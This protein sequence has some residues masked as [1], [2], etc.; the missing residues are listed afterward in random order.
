MRFASSI[1]TFSC[2]ALLAFVCVTNARPLRAQCESRPGSDG[3][4]AAPSRP[5]NANTADI[6]Q[7]GVTEF[8][9][10][11]SRSLMGAGASQTDLPALLRFSP[12]CNLEVRMSSDN[13]MSLHQNGETTHGLGDS[14]FTAQYEL[15]R[16]T[17]YLPSVALAYSV[18]FPIADS[19][20]G[21]GSGKYD[22][23]V[24]FLTNKSIGQT[25]FTFNAGYN[26]VGRPG[27]SG[28][29]RNTYLAANF[30]RPLYKNLGFTG[31]L[32]G[33]TRL[34]AQT[35][36]YT[37]TLWALTY[38]INPRLVVDGGIDK[39]VNGSVPGMRVYFGVSYA[40]GEVYPAL[41]H[42]RAREE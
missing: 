20:T 36:G 6:L 37:G 40:I 41:R 5:N 33:A 11:Y 31:E 25:V 14:W 12:S 42:P 9:Y 23:N 16:Q 7:Q 2:F 24:T 30:A 10:G 35:A 13:F 15:F 38:T 1:K 28:F 8:E 18:K 21:L 32:Y 19:S 3:V 4:L 39:G 29:N 17:G 22:H 34:G 27:L 26:L